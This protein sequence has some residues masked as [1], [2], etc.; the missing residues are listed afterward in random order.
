M[1]TLIEPQ[2]ITIQ[3]I[4]GIVNQTWISRAYYQQ[5]EI[6]IDKTT[7][8][9]LISSCNCNANCELCVIFI[10]KEYTLNIAKKIKLEFAIYRILFVCL[11][12][13][14]SQDLIK[15]QSS[16]QI[17]M[18]KK[19]NKRYDCRQVIGIVKNMLISSG[20]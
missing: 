1:S 20:P 5:L 2:L 16:G 17:L 6:G 9:L 7:M 18:S 11:L 19:N 4:L 14:T 10:P 12:V 13:V 8:S 15:K 3:F